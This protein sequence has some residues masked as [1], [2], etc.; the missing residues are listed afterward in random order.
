[1]SGIVPTYI[2]DPRLLRL[3]ASET[4]APRNSVFVE[5]Q[6]CTAAEE[7]AGSNVG[8]VG[9]APQTVALGPRVSLVTALLPPPDS[10]I[11]QP[12]LEVHHPQLTR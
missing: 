1:M 2:K 12:G 9:C 4:P 8:F 6:V 10:V 3:L 7:W 11:Y 5:C